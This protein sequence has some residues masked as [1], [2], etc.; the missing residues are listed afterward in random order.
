[1]STDR[2]ATTLAVVVALIVAVGAFS[3][4]VVGA[5]E[6]DVTV[7]QAEDGSATVTVTNENETGVENASVTVET[8]DENATYE[9]TGNYTSDDNGTVDLAAPEEN[10]TVDVT[11]A[12]N[13]LT[14]N[15]TV[16]L[17]V[18]DTNATNQTNQTAL[19]ESFGLAVS[20]YV[21]SLQNDSNVTGGLGPALAS[22]VVANNPGNAPSHA[23]PPE[24]L[25]RGPPADRGPSG[26]RGPPGDA[27]PPENRTQGQ[28]DDAGPPEDRGPGDQG[29]DRNGGNGGPPEDAGGGPDDS[30]DDDGDEADRGGGNGGNA[31]GGNGNGPP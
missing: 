15:T 24:D 25:R 9:G 27:G 31:G 19:N 6:L 30:D 8:T 29:P 10:V 3:G 26:D 2:A 28:P 21:F 17:L 18:A 20:A 5:E 7:E 1:M 23:G 22:W 14:A 13:N 16:T 12:K 11:A 4:G